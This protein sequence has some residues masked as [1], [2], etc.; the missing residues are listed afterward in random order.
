MYKVYKEEKN[1]KDNVV[2][3]G[4]CNR[5]KCTVMDT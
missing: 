1:N 3:D 5:A 4:K 2:R